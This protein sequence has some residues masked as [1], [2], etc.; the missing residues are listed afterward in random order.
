MFARIGLKFTQ[1]IGL[2]DTSFPTVSAYSVRQLPE[3]TGLLALSAKRAYRRG[4]L[5]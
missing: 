3:D 4:G 2:V 1:G 5:T